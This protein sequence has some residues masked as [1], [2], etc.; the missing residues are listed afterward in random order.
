M[1]CCAA[2][3]PA[4][5]PLPTKKVLTLAAAKEMAAAAEKHAAENKWN[6]CISIVDDSGALIYFQRMDGTQVAS[7]AISQGK[8]ETAARFKRP[9]KA[10]EEAV[11]MGRTVVLALPGVV[12]VEGGLPIVVDGNVIGAIGVS[13]VK[14]T[15]DAQ[16]GQ[17]GIDALTKLIE[18][19]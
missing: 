5:E 18:K 13:G 14:S 2:A 16:V 17:A 10:L 12:P 6:V 8:A 1:A 4:A 7:V 3:V 19:K 11:M 15:E 9:T